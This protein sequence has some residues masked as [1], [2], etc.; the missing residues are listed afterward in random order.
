M[1]KSWAKKAAVESGAVRVASSLAAK[2]IAILMYHSVADGSDANNQILGGI[3]HSPSSFRQQMELLAREYHPI[4]LEEAVLYVQDRRDVARR[5]VV[6]TFDDGYADN[7][8]VAMPLL[9]EIGVPATF[10][11]TVGCVEQKKLPWPG[12]LRYALFTTRNSAWLDPDGQSWPLQGSMLRS[13]AFDRACEYCSKLAGSEQDQFVGSAESQLQSALTNGPAMMTWDEVRAAVKQGHIIGSHTL[14]HP[15]MAHIKEDAL[16]REMSESKNIL[17]RELGIPVP[18][19]S[20]PCPALQPHW[21]ERTVRVSQ[22]SGYQSAVTTSQG[23]ACR[24]DNPLHLKRI[25]ARKNVD[26]LRASLEFAF[27]G[28]TT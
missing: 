28:F 3:G 2:G 4:S 24:N 23:L 16:R 21:T 8:H 19:F 27:L 20:Y 18:H 10:Y 7:Y 5:S 6:V 17:E 15:N 26:D 14:S 13:Q 12:R 11:V 22:E 9:N 25:G 1:L